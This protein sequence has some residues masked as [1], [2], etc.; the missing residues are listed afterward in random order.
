[1]YRN[2]GGSQCRGW[3]HY[4]EHRHAHRD[5]NIRGLASR[6]RRYHLLRILRGINPRFR[7]FGYVTIYF[8]TMV[9]T[10]SH[11]TSGITCIIKVPIAFVHST[12]Q[13]LP[14][15]EYCDLQKKINQSYLPYIMSQKNFPTTTSKACTSI[16]ILAECTYIIP[17]PRLQNCAMETYNCPE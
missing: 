7:F 5:T 10:D 9:A 6:T 13:S 15:L 14:P 2:H 12:I 4:R 3:L 11:S 17:P 1:M 8:N 16:A